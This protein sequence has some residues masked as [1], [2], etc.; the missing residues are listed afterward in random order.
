[1]FGKIHAVETWLSFCYADHSG[2]MVVARTEDL[3]CKR[4]N[5]GPL[6]HQRRL[7]T[8]LFGGFMLAVSTVFIEWSGN[9]AAVGPLMTLAA[10]HGLAAKL[11]FFRRAEVKAGRGRAPVRAA[12]R[13]ERMNDGAVIFCRFNAAKL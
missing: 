8:A 2:R 6:A 10:I 4:A 7:E 5:G 9:Q 1:M 11:T 13:Y 12:I 3:A